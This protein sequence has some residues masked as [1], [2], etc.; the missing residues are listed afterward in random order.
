MKNAYRHTRNTSLWPCGV[1][2]LS[3]KN[4]KANDAEHAKRFRKIR[5][6]FCLVSLTCCV[7]F[8]HEPSTLVRCKFNRFRCLWFRSPTLPN[9]TDI[10]LSLFVSPFYINGRRS[11][12][13]LCVCKHPHP[14]LLSQ[15]QAVFLKMAH[16]V[17]IILTP[18][19]WCFRSSLRKDM[20]SV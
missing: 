17:A 11:S 9:C 5:K 6:Q 14:T 15:H 18:H 20:K 3:G 16:T 2:R 1:R 13:I 8:W 10:V 7:A 12:L 19:Y 4:I